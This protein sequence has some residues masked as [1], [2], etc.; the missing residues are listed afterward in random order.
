MTFHPRQNWDPIRRRRWSR[1]DF[2]RTSAAVGIGVPSLSALLAAC[3]GDDAAT[4][5]GGGTPEVLRGTPT[6]PVTQPL[7]SDN[8]MIASGLQAEDGPLRLYN[9]D[10]YINPDVLPKAERALDRKIELATFYNLEESIQKLRSGEVQ[11][12]VWFPT[13]DV[14]GQ[15]VAGQLL[16][17]LNH[18][19]LPNLAKHVWPSL[20]DPY[21]DKGSQ[22]SV[23][24]VVYQTGIGWR[25][26]EVDS[27]DVEDIENPW[28]VF[29]NDKY[30]GNTGLYDDF[31]ESLPMSM[32]RNR[33]PDAFNATAEQVNAAADSL[34]ELGDLMNIRYT[35]DGAYA[36][37]PEDRFG[38]HLAWSGDMVN[39]QY[40]FPKGG[41]PS[42]TR[43]LWPGNS[44]NST[45]NG[46]I[47]NDSMGVLK[48][49]RSPVLAHQFLNWM[50][51][52]R[53][54]LDNFSWLGY[55]PPQVGLDT[56][57]LV[58]DEWV[59]DYLAPAIVREEDFQAERG[60]VPI[61][62]APETERMWT[63]A[64]SRVQSGG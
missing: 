14:M 34:I 57:Q 54:A 12:D 40:Y 43:Y 41:D 46:I 5:S 16:Q 38:L 9:W 27:A 47:S 59:P 28:D 30:K 44:P 7:S 8:P 50:L 2:L 23:P 51:A 53:H 32:F 6:N 55:Q 22:Y 42:V 29:W 21:Y 18:E 37:I 24:Y 31:R 56:E 4:T 20:A 15:A 26:D 19:Y 25:T 39:A 35:I 58:A 45:V 33:V 3:G 60:T 61:Q 11:Y 52:E 49:A 62:L 13:A 63:D 10:Q 48:G 1:R 17:P 64:W 36:G